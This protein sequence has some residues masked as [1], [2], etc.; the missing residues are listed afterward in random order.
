MPLNHMLIFAKLHDAT[1]PKTVIFRFLR[2]FDEDYSKARNF[3]AFI[4]VVTKHV[5]IHGNIISLMSRHMP[6]MCM[7]IR[8]YVLMYVLK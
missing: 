8:T 7:Y 2:I 5:L 1:S 4:Y 3:S 6:Y